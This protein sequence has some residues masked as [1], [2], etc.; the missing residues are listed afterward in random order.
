MG[1]ALDAGGPGGLG[2]VDGALDVQGLEL[3]A[4]GLEQ[5]ADQVDHG[6]GAPDRLGHGGLVGDVAADGLDLADVAGH[7]QLIGQGG[8]AHGDAHAPAALGQGP[9][10]LG[11]DKAR[12]AEN[13]D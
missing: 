12:A 7:A 6:V 13:G 2:D 11:S 4:A 3:A 8:L 1:Q 5:D 10:H 9:H